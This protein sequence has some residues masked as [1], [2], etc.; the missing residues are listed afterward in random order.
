MT[1][2]Q[3][4]MREKIIVTI[5]TIIF[6]SPAFFVQE[7]PRLFYGL[8]VGAIGWAIGKKIVLYLRKKER[9]KK[10]HPLLSNSA[11]FIYVLI[12]IILLVMIDLKYLQNKF[13]LY[14]LKIILITYF[15]LYG[16]LKSMQTKKGWIRGF[17][18]TKRA[19]LVTGIIEVMIAILLLLWGILIR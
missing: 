2:E 8:F 11:I 9:K 14:L 15:L 6:V 7:G 19:A 13:L 16:G 17:P 18:L 5:I 4:M 12:Y 3:L 10:A 1:K